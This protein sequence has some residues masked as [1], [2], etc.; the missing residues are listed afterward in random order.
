MCMI[1]SERHPMGMSLLPLVHL[2]RLCVAPKPFSAASLAGKG[3]RQR[4]ARAK[5][6]INFQRLNGTSKLVAF[7]TLFIPHRLPHP[8]FYSSALDRERLFRQEEVSYGPA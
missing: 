3:D 1:G 2:I 4:S 8:Q 5:A 7:P 6:P